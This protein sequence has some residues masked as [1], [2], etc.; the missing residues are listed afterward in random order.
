M[1]NT[2][3][4]IKVIV[5]ANCMKGAERTVAA[6]PARLW[7]IASQQTEVLAMNLCGS[8]NRP[9]RDRILRL[10]QVVCDCSGKG[11]LDNRRGG[12]LWTLRHVCL[13]DSYLLGGLWYTD[14]ILEPLRLG[15]FP[16]EGDSSL[17]S[18]WLWISVFRNT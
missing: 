3:I 11:F 2:K 17:L 10:W 4:H 6:A 9:I 13:R 14:R 8:E 7:L 15:N 16:R 5:R 1:W 12:T 18:A